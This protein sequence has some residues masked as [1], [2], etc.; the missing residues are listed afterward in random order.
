[1][2]EDLRAFNLHELVQQSGERGGVLDDG[3]A[4]FDDRPTP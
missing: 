3:A 4:D 2:H 1:M